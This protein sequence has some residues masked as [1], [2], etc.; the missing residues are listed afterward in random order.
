MGTGDGHYDAPILRLPG[1]RGGGGVMRDPRHQLGTPRQPDS[2][3][4][5]CGSKGGGEGGGGASGLSVRPI[6]GADGGC[7]SG[8]MGGGEGGGRDGSGELTQLHREVV[9][10]MVGA[11]EEGGVGRVSGGSNR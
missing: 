3:G 11:A 6:C 4:G 5:A 2:E 10:V 7:P 9:V 8:D 1:R